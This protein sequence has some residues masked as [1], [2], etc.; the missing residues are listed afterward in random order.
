MSNARTLPKAAQFIILQCLLMAIAAC[1]GGSGSNA[2]GPDQP[3]VVPYTYAVPAELGDLWTVG[4]ANT[5]GV[6]AEILEAMM[7]EIQSGNFPLIDSIAVARRGVLVLSETVRTITGTADERVGNADPAMHAQNSVS[8]SFAAALTGIAI[9]QG[10]FEN[11]EVPYLSLF[12]YPDYENRD[13]RKDNITLQHV[14]TMT[15]GLDWNEW[16]PPYSDPD[17][18]MFTH[19]ATHVD[20]SKGL[21]DL[22]MAFDPGTRFAYNTIASVS[23]GQ[24]IEN[25]APLSLIDYGSA[26]FLAPLGITRIEVERTP[27]GLPDLGRGLFLTTRDMLK[28]GQLYLDNGEWQ[29][30]QVVSSDWVSRST[31]VNVELEWAEPDGMVWQMEGYGYHWWLGTFTVD[32]RRYDSYA[33]WGFGEQ[34]LMV[35][36]ELE[37]VVAVNA[38]GRNGTAEESNEILSLIRDYVLVSALQ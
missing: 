1:G 8:K 24:A 10:V 13:D 26:F 14:L 37:L 15:L 4:H 17:N 34:W 16:E 36:P 5:V 30:R 22:P 25:N 2:N 31:T 38:H 33:A 23:L 20:V 35:I 19:Y 3:P 11:T 6:S 7:A 12:P 18:Q 32:G 9:D 29:G 21:L 28:L 27:S